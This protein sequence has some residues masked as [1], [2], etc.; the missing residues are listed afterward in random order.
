ERA[1][2]IPRGD[3]DTVHIAAPWCDGDLTDRGSAR[4][5]TADGGKEGAVRDVLAEDHL[6]L[7]NPEVPGGR[8]SLRSSQAATRVDGGG[9]LR[10]RARRPCRPCGTGGA[11][12]PPAAPRAPGGPGGPCGPARP[13][14]PGRSSRNLAGSEV[15]AE[16]R[17][18]LD[19]RRGDR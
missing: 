12:P 8:R 7:P 5:R 11:R 17:A 14:G 1:R 6:V 4:G 10:D 2:R 3:E 18:V 9:Q 13:G 15:G 16:K 19:L